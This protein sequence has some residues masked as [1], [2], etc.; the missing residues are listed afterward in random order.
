MANALRCQLNLPEAQET[1]LSLLAEPDLRVALLAFSGLAQVAS[2]FASSDLFER[3][4]QLLARLGSSAKTI[5]SG[6]WPWLLIRSDASSVLHAM[7]ECLGERNPTRLIVYVPRMNAWY[8]I[9]TAE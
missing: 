8:R 1:V 2:T 9:H 5:G 7:I 6:V 3:F 4:E